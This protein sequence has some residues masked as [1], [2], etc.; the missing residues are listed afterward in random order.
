MAKCEH[1]VYTKRFG[2]VE[3]AAGFV[4]GNLRWAKKTGQTR[5]QQHRQLGLW[6]DEEIVI[7]ARRRGLTMI[8]K[9]CAVT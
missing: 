1:S 9:N 3:H 4:P 6:T 2:I 8:R 7:E 5:N